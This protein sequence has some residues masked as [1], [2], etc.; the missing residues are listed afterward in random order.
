MIRRDDEALRGLMARLDE[1]H[2]A[3]AAS[4]ARS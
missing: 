4:G 3:F 2:S 1:N